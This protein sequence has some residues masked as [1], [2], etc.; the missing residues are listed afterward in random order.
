VHALVWP[1]IDLW[2]LRLLPP[3][4][5]L[6][7]IFTRLYRSGRSLRISGQEGQ[8]PLEFARHLS[9]RLSALLEGRRNAPDHNAQA[10]ILWLGDEYARYRYS[11]HDPDAR[12]RSR[13][14]LAWR[15]LRRSLLSARLRSLRFQWP[16]RRK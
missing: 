15:G 1:T 3:R 13:A 10:D 4:S 16:L 6:D 9:D 2:R 12:V 11:K 8:T 7:T 5:A 14:V